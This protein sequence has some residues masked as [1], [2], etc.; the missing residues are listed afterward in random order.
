M[1]CPA[2]LRATRESVPLPYS[3]KI[4]PIVLL[5]L[6]SITPAFAQRGVRSSANY[7]L[8]AESLDSGGAASTGATYA[9][10]GSMGTLGG[11]AS[12]ANPAEIVKSGYL[13]QLYEVAGFVVSAAPSTLAEGST[14]Q[15]GRRN[16]STMPL[17]WRSI[18]RRSPGVS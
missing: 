18:R 15:L 3:M 1:N 17:I 5:L 6:A 13:G 16:S 14:R 11:M 10:V 2:T 8:A 9:H 4:E 7:A 12:V